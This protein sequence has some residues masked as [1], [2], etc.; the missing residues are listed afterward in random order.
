MARPKKKATTPAEQTNLHLGSSFEA[1]WQN[2]ILPWFKTVGL[3]ACRSQQPAV[4]V[5]PYPSRAPFFRQLLVEAKVPLLGVNFVSPPQLREMLL[6]SDRIKL[7][8]REHL[9]LLLSIAAEQEMAA[10]QSGDDETIA[11]KSVRRAPDHLLRTIDELS[12][13][14]WTFAEA[15]PPSFRKLVNRFE[16]LASNCGFTS[17]QQADRLA[18]AKTQA[19]EKI[20]GNLLVAGFD[21]AHWP[22]WPL[23]RAAVQASAQSTIILT[24][25]RDEAR[26][27]DECWVGTWEQALGAATPID[28]PPSTSHSTPVPASSAPQLELFAEKP[29]P[30]VHFLLGR[31]TT[32]EA[33]AIV[34]VVLNFLNDATGGRIGVLFPAPGALAR[35]V[36]TRLAGLGIPH[37]DAIGHP[38]APTLEDLS[39][40]AWL[41]LQENNRLHPLLNFLATME[42]SSS[43]FEDV[44]RTRIEDVLRRTFSAILVDDL[45]VLQEYCA[46][47]SDLEAAP[48][49]AARIASVRLLPAA[50]TLPEFVATTLEILDQFKWKNRKAELE[51]LSKDWTEKVDSVF[52]RES[53]L[54]WLSEILGKPKR[55]RDEIG[56]H[57]YSRIQLLSLS[58]AEGQSWSHLIF[59][60]L[61]EGAWPPSL[62]ESDFVRDAEIEALNKKIKVLNRR[63][64]V[65][66]RQ[67]EG[68]WSVQEGKTMCLGT[69]ER[70]LLALRQV[71]NLMESAGR[72]LAVTASLFTE[73]VPRRIANPSEFFT[74]LYFDHHKK[75]LSQTTLEA[76][77]QQTRAWIEQ[78]GLAGQPAT[79]DKAVGQT[80]VAFDARR[81]EA[82]A[83]EFEFALR[84][85]LA[86]AISFSASAS[87]RLFKSPA[88]IWMKS[89][90][91]VQGD[92]S[93]EQW[94]LAV[95][96]W[97]H[98]W[99]RQ[100][101]DCPTPDSFGPLDANLPQRVR[102]AA[103]QFQDEIGAMLRKF[104]RPVPDWWTSTWNN[105]VYIANGFVN[106]VAQT[107]DWTHAGTEWSLRNLPAIQV[108]DGEGLKLRG[109][110]DLILA[111]AAPDLNRFEGIPLWV[112]D[113]KTGKRESLRSSKWKSE[114]EIRQGALKKLLKGDGI[115]V[116]LYAL[117]LHQLGAEDIGISLL[118]RGLDL[119][120][121]QLTLPEVAVHE[122]VWSELARMQKAGVFGMRGLI[123]S[124]FNFT[125]D[126]PLAT[127][128]IDYDLLET[129]WTL[130]HPAFAAGDTEE[131]S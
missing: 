19:A 49:V 30:N 53:Y 61:N 85:P 63:A 16:R 52:S 107:K 100:I 62:N 46:R 71:A 15:G 45:T 35:S 108:G 88:L 98:G 94:S 122:Q 119:S 126:Y 65:Q 27:L 86:R 17:I 22:L 50:A 25:P 42:D 121:P 10:G 129:K 21:G 5:L 130:T 120:A 77:Q 24:D 28:A 69:G 117:A 102:A 109:R 55:A 58:E 48:A 67:G 44:P 75:A 97:V 87:E 111:K 89:F 4:V 14:G 68:Q 73:S 74:R 66:G 18:L 36:A 79:A 39:W 72:G 127:L 112:V 78:T 7:P 101:V 34:A 13:G 47:H 23:L 33:D 104:G 20:F 60:G 56:D 6:D 125:G 51:R 40:L 29:A 1:A 99:L 11:A 76:I 41:R 103:R 96:N 26:D 8:L 114:E 116:A 54:R 38:I 37:H 80:R 84:E 128:A 81:K 43:L 9:R 70:R 31:E 123:R 57:P 64:V 115:Q 118:A 2:V 82:K 91:G 124:E 95:G 59:T 3:A 90:L 93:N 106:H 131:E 113:Y 92:E 105:A 12:A 83:G 32:E 110:I